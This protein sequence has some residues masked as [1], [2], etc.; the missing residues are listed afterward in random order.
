MPKLSEDLYIEKGYLDGYVPSSF[1]SQH[2]SL[3]RTLTWLGMGCILTSLAGFGCLMFGLA[4]GVVH[5]QEHASSYAIGGAVFGV[6]MLL[7]G[8][9]L[10]HFGRANYRAYK[11]RTGRIH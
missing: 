1:D 8:F 11:K 7:L 2:S 3:H 6:G 4:A 10:V 9:A 5:S